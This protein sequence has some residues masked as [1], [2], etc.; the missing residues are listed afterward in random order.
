MD[1]N[2][3]VMA[4]FE[5]IK[6]TVTFNANSGSGIVPAAQTVNAGSIITLPGV[7]GLTPSDF[8]TLGGWSL[9]TSGTGTTYAAYSTFTPEG[10]VTLY[11]KWD[12]VTTLADKLTWLQTYAA[13][14]SE[15]ILDVST[16]E[17]ISPLTL[18]RGKTITLRGDGANRVISLSSNGSMFSVQS[19]VTLVLDNNITLKGHSSN[20]A[21]L[22]TVSNNGTL[23]MNNGVAITGNTYNTGNSGSGGGVSVSG[24]F[25]MNGGTISGNTAYVG[26]GVYVYGSRSS[27][28]MNGGTISGNTSSSLGN[29]YLQSGATVTM[30]GGTISGNICPE[31]WVGGV[32]VYNGSSF[33]MSGGTISGNTNYGVYVQLSGI[34]T[35][36]GGT[37]TGSSTND[38]NGN[39]NYAVYAYSSD[40]NKRKSTTSDPS[41]NLSFDSTADPPTWSGA[42]DD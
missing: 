12:A 4:I 23:I 29:I 33:I 19:G 26:G 30:S 27:V 41:D 9:N 8:T 14:G 31:F 24:I 25:I 32:G 15:Y 34:F 38:P 42:W 7:S 36:T 5:R 37:I 6:Y 21:S 39:G 28:T 18:S 40:L 2:K 22:V 20:T 11:A 3:M 10:D 13:N 16:D 17:S 35:K 1:G